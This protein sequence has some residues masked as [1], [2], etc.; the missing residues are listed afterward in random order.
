MTA[1]TFGSE[2]QRLRLQAKMSLREL[3]AKAPCSS[4]YLSRI[5]GGKRRPSPHV[6]GALDRALRAGGTL[7]VLA[8]SSIA[9]RLDENCQ[10]DGDDKEDRAVRR[11]LMAA[12]LTVAGWPPLSLDGWDLPRRV[13]PE[14]VTDVLDTIQMYRRWV[15][16]HGGAAIRGPLAVLL[17]RAA[18]LHAAT[19]DSNVRTALVVAIADAAA[20]SAYVARDLAEH[21]DAE[22]HY[23]LALSAAHAGHST[24]LG[25]HVMVRTAG[26]HLEL[27]RPTQA[28]AIL[29]AVSGRADAALTA[30]DVANQRCLEAWAH[31]QAGNAQAAQRAAHQADDAFAEAD[32]EQRPWAAQ[33]AT[34]AELHSLIGVTYVELARHQRGHAST[35]IDR[36]DRAM[37]L[38]CT[39]GA[40]N[41][42][43]DHVSMAEALL[44][45][46]DIDE[47]GR[48]ALRALDAAIGITSARVELRLDHLH[49][50]LVDHVDHHE[51]VGE[52]IAR[53]TQ[54][55]GDRC[56]PHSGP[57]AP[58][59]G[60]R[61]P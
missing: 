48:V 60:C 24:E 5:E 57:E 12:S 8:G 21:G 53:R 9:D 3:A 29:K 42:A 6:A 25:T 33:H 34:E 47:A 59:P 31:A 38:R 35:A 45:L 10:D 11:G 20:L 2:L 39:S 41:R 23:R 32:I 22:E 58:G 55:A 52:F 13:G 50:R 61:H 44:H 36:L 46:E 49:Q 15:T 18:A 1:P 4:G 14:H 40:R 51:P 37:Q 26:H 16:R 19:A 28:L 7:V 54:R 56:L 27:R 17:E 30:N 43:L